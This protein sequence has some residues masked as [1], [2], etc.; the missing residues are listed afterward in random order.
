MAM[1]EQSTVTVLMLYV[2]GMWTG[3]R[4][5]IPNLGQVDTGTKCLLRKTLLDCYDG[6]N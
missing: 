3:K 5:G 2:I 4:I 1:G 6:Y